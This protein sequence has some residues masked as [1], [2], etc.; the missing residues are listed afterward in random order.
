MRA[1]V[2]VDFTLEA[3]HSLPHLPGDHKCKRIHGHSYKIRVTCEGEADP[4][5]G[6]VIDYADIKQVFDDKVHWRCDHKNI[7]DIVGFSTSENFAK[8]IYEQMDGLLGGLL[9]EVQVQETAR[10]GAVYRG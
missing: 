4:R 7:N 9:I 6:W 2:W 8:W 1:R 10:A 3:A 5:T